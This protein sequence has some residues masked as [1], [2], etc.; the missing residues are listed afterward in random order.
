MTQLRLTTYFGV[1]SRRRI[2]TTEQLRPKTTKPWACSC[3]NA[4][5][6][7]RLHFDGGYRQA[8]VLNDLGTLILSVE[9]AVDEHDLR[10]RQ[11]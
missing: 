8:L 2:T 4:Y 7:W 9:Y 11:Q 10:W 6:L 5:C 1:K 3:E